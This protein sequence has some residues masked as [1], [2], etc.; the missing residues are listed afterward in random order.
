MQDPWLPHSVKFKLA[1]GCHL[2]HSTKSY[3]GRS[4][5]Q[6]GLLDSQRHLCAQGRDGDCPVKY[7]SGH[8][9]F[10]SIHPEAGSHAT[11]ERE[12]DHLCV[13]STINCKLPT[14]LGFGGTMAQC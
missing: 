2:I 9:Y 5:T 4:P 14:H 10:W 7:L 12:R 11:K 6:S 3:K 8:R 13:V 1:I